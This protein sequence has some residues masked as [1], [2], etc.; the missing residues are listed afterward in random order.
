VPVSVNNGFSYS[1][2]GFD[3][4]K[5]FTVPGIGFFEL[6]GGYVRSRDNGPAATTGTVT[7]NAWYVES[8]QYITGPEL[9]FYERYSMTDLNG[10]KPK[11][12]RKDYTVGAVTPI[13]T[14]FRLAAEY[15]YSDN[16]NTGI[17]AHLAL[18]ELQA[19]W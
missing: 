13:E 3:V 2:L 8:Q 4:N 7:G 9:T 5:I 1:R 10:P 15:T 14:W 11:S 16:R 12:T 18:L 6:M 17:T 19:A